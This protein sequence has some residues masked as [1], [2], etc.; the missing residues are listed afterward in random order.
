MYLKQSANTAETLVF[1]K[2]HT[3]YY[4]TTTV[5]GTRPEDFA[6]IWDFHIVGR[7]LSVMGNARV[8][9][10]SRHE[11]VS[12]KGSQKFQI[13]ATTFG[14]TESK[15]ET[16]IGFSNLRISGYSKKN[17][18]EYSMFHK[19]FPCGNCRLRNLRVQP[20]SV[21]EIGI[22]QGFQRFLGFLNKKFDERVSHLRNDFAYEHLRF[23]MDLKKISR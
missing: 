19:G 6:E 22:G 16:E 7:M 5:F 8:I 10:A 20:L 3:E 1:L 14:G 21:V 15:I 9:L 11:V 23:S 12:E 18:K 17:S 13:F 4:R 2:N